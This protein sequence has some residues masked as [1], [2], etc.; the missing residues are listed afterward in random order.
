MGN[1][2]TL[3]SKGNASAFSQ[4]FE[5]QYFRPLQ[6]LSYQIDYRLWHLN[7]SG[8][9]LTNILLHWFVALSAYQF[10]SLVSGQKML[11]LF[12][13]MVFC[14][15]PVNTS[16]VAYI[17][18][19]ADALAALFI[20]LSFICWI[21]ASNFDGRWILSI[22]F[23]VFSLFSKEV[24]VALPVFLLGY[25]LL[26][27]KGSKSLKRS[28]LKLAPFLAML[29]IYLLVRTWNVGPGRLQPFNVSF[30]AFLLT[31]SKILFLYAAMLLFPH[32]L[33]LGHDTALATSLH[34]GALL[35]FAGLFFAAV[36]S[37]W[38]YKRS[39]D[40]LFFSIWFFLFLFAQ[41]GFMHADHVG[42]VLTAEHWAYL[43]SIGFYFVMGSL[44]RQFVHK[45]FGN[46]ALGSGA[47]I[48]GGGVVGLLTLL[49][50]VGTVRANRYW[51]SE[52]LLY[53]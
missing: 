14:V 9:R 22:V 34:P 31:V 52:L 16:V 30:P 51:M 39:K 50:I 8:F 42:R 43:P 46:R 23:F 19:R 47:Q 25:E 13:S 18:G 29:F 7:P 5:V 33:Y 40:A 4:R 35:F 10:I 2:G 6:I 41:F 1:P 38:F 49:C 36:L 26:F 45:I 21:K 3:F 12:S 37:I 32:P 15:H 28:F 20:L 48:A 44:I 24:A 27:R 11:A 53:D 17:S